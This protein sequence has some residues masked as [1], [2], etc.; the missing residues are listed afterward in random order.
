M[1]TWLLSLT[2]SS[3]NIRKII[4]ALKVSDADLCY[5]FVDESSQFMDVFCA[6]LLDLCR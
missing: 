6:E 4:A 5:G 3:R 1:S 2:V